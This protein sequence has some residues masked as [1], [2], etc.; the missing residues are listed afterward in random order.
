[1]TEGGRQTMPSEPTTLWLEDF[2]PGQVFSAGP[3]TITERDLLFCALWGG[4]GQPHSNEE[5]S[6]ATP[7][8]SRIVHGDGTL[9]MGTGLIHGTGLFADSLIGCESMEIR[10]PNPVYIGDAIQ[11]Q[12]KIEA[13]KATTPDEGIVDAALEISKDAGMKPVVRV[14]TRYRVRRKP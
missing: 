5:Y 9:A 3:R 2:S 12:L 7:F 6:R 13:V 11:A 4:D 10:Y 14:Q 8:G 1:M